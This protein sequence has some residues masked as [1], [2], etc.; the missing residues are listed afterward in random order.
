MATYSSGYRRQL[1]E[2]RAEVDRQ[3]IDASS[4]RCVECNV[5]GPCLPR[6]DALYA[7]AAMH[8]LPRRVAS[9]TRPEQINARWVRLG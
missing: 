1:D 7:L 9:A 6:R 2:L 5:V 4:D 3:T 8:E